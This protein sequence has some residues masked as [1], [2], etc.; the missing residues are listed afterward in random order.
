MCVY[1]SSF[2]QTAPCNKSEKAPRHQVDYIKNIQTDPIYVLNG[3]F[4]FFMPIPLFSFFLECHKINTFFGKGY[5]VEF[6]KFFYIQLELSSQVKSSVD[7][8]YN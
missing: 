1:T 2:R 5:I 4:T 8:C 7:K 6:K 3:N